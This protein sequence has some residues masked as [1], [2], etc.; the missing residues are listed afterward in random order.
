MVQIMDLRLTTLMSNFRFKNWKAGFWIADRK[1]LCTWH[2]N[3]LSDPHVRQNIIILILVELVD[4]LFT[5][6]DH[7]FSSTEMMWFVFWRV[8]NNLEKEENA[9]YQPFAIS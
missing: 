1:T 9:G 7:K 6:P 3:L 2:F 4:L 8:K 5:L